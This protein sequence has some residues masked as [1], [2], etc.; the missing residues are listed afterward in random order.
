MT[1]I[2]IRRATTLFALTLFALVSFGSRHVAAQDVVPAPDPRPSPLSIA[3][4]TLD[5]GTYVKIHYSSPRKRGR[6]IFGGL[7]PFKKVWRFGANEATELTVTQPITLGGKPVAPGTYAVFAI[8]GEDEWTIIL[9][10]NLGQWGAFSY[11]EEDDYTR[12]AASAS[13]TDKTHEAF[14]INLEKNEEQPGA[15]M[16]VVWDTTR[17]TIP[18]RAQN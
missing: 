16:I 11:A 1:A 6:A 17:V 14:T 13:K 3:Q 18:I 4:V 10:K 8:P 7:V 15:E 12:I 9:N 2:Q 5:D